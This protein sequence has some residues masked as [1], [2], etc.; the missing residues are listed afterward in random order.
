MTPAFHILQSFDLKHVGQRIDMIKKGDEILN[1][2]KDEKDKNKIEIIGPGC[3][4][5]KRLYQQVREVAAEQGIAAD[6]LHV[7]DIKTVLRYIPFTP[8]LKVNDQIVHR[9]KRLPTKEKLSELI[10]SVM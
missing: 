3:Y 4:F 5:C 6:I 8:V 7:T 10:R 9:G 1:I 2:T